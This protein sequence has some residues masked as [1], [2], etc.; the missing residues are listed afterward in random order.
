MSDEDLWGPEPFTDTRSEQQKQRDALTARLNDI[1]NTLANRDDLLL[2]CVWDKPLDDPS[3]PG[4]PAW[5]DPRSAQ[6]TVNATYALQGRDPATVEPRTAAGRGADPVIVGLLCHEAGHAHS[7]AWGETPLSDGSLSPAVR[8]AAVLLEEPRIEYRQLQRRPHDLPFLRAQSALIDLGPF[9]SGDALSSST[10]QWSLGVCALMTLGRRDA[11]VLQASDVTAVEPLLGDLL[12]SDVLE[13]LQ[14]VWASALALDDG[15]VDGLIATAERWNEVLGDPPQ[16]V[17][18][19]PVSCTEHDE[20]ADSQ[21]CEGAGSPNG[22]DGGTESGASQAD[23]GDSGD[24]SAPADESPADSTDGDL[25]GA[26]ASLLEDVA[27][28][29]RAEAAFAAQQDEA[30]DQRQQAAKDVELQKAAQKAATKLLQRSRRSVTGR[31]PQPAERALANSFARALRQAQF[32]ERTATQVRSDTPPGRIDGRDAML[33]SAQ[34]AR[35]DVVTARPFRQTVRRRVP[36]PPLSVGTMVD[37]SSSMQWATQILP[38][39]AW[40]FSHAAHSIHGTAATVAFG[41]KVTPLMLPGSP[42]TVVPTITADDATEK[43]AEGFAVVDGALNLTCGKG[44]RVLV[45]VSDGVFVGP[46]ELDAGRCAVARLLRNGAHVIWVH[47]PRSESYLPKKVTRI[48]FTSV[49]ELPRQ[50]EIALAQIVAA[51]R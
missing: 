17:Q 41:S 30:R 36:E 45:V 19:L 39:L 7:T 32:R 27:E 16:D 21:D 25:T 24:G 6:V 18:V 14:S 2:D 4:A 15:D 3:L 37:V 34:R 5:F 48:Q 38:S 12:G 44:A 47:P 50:L 13:A 29:G 43:F 33:G 10:G 51:S 23:G 8:K 40:A 26:L 22:D 20:S 31:T 46:G 28:S 11:G 9:S 49:V 35:G 1:I 42:A